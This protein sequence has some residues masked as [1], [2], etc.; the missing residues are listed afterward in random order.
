MHSFNGDPCELRLFSGYPC[1]YMQADGGPLRSE[2]SGEA[3][4]MAPDDLLVGYSHPTNSL[5]S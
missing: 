3:D 5:Y 4:S 1:D 2:L